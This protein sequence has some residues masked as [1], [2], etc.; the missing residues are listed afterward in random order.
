[1]Y[2]KEVEHLK[3]FVN[4]SQDNLF[5]YKD[6]LIG[7]CLSLSLRN[8]QSRNFRLNKLT[9]YGTLIN[10]IR[11]DVYAN[12]NTQNGF[13]GTLSFFLDLE[14]QSEGLSTV[15][16]IESALVKQWETIGIPTN[17]SPRER[18][19][20]LKEQKLGVTKPL[21]DLYIEVISSLSNPLLKQYCANNLVTKEDF[22]NFKLRFLVLEYEQ[23]LLEVL[24]I[25]SEYNLYSLDLGGI[26][27]KLINFNQIGSMVLVYLA[28]VIEGF[29]SCIRY[30]DSLPYDLKSMPLVEFIKSNNFVERQNIANYLA[31]SFDAATYLVPVFD[32][33]VELAEH[34]FSE[35][36]KFIVNVIP[37]NGG[38]RLNE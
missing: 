32:D 37:D 19:I 16:L 7:L 13:V 25:G 1:V 9:G 23:D 3:Y 35:L 17:I 6:M 5:T 15:D 26:V 31:L 18:Y 27:T 11:K 4:A 28:Y 2:Q 36:K 14:E 29:I 24:K 34:V 10:L 38:F 8:S 21:T 22:K 30:I 20:Y 12:Q 33:G